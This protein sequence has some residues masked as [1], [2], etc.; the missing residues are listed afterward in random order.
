MTGPR[1]EGNKTFNHTPWRR[2]HIRQNIKAGFASIRKPNDPSVMPSPF[3]L[4]GSGRRGIQHLARIFH[5]FFHILIGVGM[6]TR[7]AGRGAQR[8]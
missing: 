8:R 4:T 2:M 5:R 3:F 6:P 7:Q 1:N